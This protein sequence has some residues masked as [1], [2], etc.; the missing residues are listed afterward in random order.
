MKHLAAALLL[1]SVLSPARAQKLN[2]FVG[3][4]GSANGAGFMQPLADAFGANIN[5]GIYQSAKIPLEGFHLNFGVMLMGAPITDSRKTFTATTDGFFTPQTTANAPTIFGSTDG[6]TVNGNAGTTYSFPGGLNMSLFALA[7]PQIT[8]GS[9]Y[10]TE[11][12]IRFFQAKLGDSVGELKLWGIGARHNINQYFKHL[13]LDVAAGIYQQHFEIGDIVSANATLISTQGSYTWSVLT[14]YGGPAVEISNMDVTYDGSNGKI[15]LALKSQN[16]V[17]FT[18]GALLSLAFFR[19]YADYNLASQ[20]AFV[21][22]F[23]FGF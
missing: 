4:Y 20:S 19:L 12:T 3:K 15:N 23:G 6:G 13:P 17:R 10:G 8:V 5:S 21:L 1:A 7:V 14:F 18:A 22:G 2:D 9:L 11:A 16:N